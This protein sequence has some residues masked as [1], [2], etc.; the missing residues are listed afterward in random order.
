VSRRPV[1]GSAGHRGAAR[2]TAV[3]ERDA[4][5]DYGVNP[6]TVIRAK[7]LLADR[8]DGAVKKVRGVYVVNPPAYDRN[9]PVSHRLGACSHCDGPRRLMKPPSPK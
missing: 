5:D 3:R 9:L 6:R 8:S 2:G 7:K 4:A 1:P